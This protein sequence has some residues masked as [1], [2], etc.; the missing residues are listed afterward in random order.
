M[1]VFFKSCYHVIVT[2][3]LGRCAKVV[4]M[5]FKMELYISYIQLKK[6]VKGNVRDTFIYFL[7]KSWGTIIKEGAFIAGNMLCINYNLDLNR[8]W[9][10]LFVNLEFLLFVN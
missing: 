4:K 8:T 3:Q 7:S 1:V 2:S 9:T 6:N 10:Y 5:L